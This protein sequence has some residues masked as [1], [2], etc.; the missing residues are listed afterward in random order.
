MFF[1]LAS[2]G[3]IDDATR[4]LA[5]DIVKQLI[6]INTTD[7]VGN[8]TTAPKP[9]HNAFAMPVSPSPFKSLVPMKVPM[10]MEISRTGANRGNN[11]GIVKFAIDEKAK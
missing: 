8:V 1:T 3:Q 11:L 5:H 4:N 10:I 2:Q 7:S 6:E 9:W